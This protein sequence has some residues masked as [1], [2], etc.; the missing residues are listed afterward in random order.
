[1]W[2]TLSPAARHSTT[3][4]SPHAGLKSSKNSVNDAMKSVVPPVGRSY[5]PSQRSPL[6]RY[7]FAFDASGTIRSSHRAF[8]PSTLNSGAQAQR[9][10][11]TTGRMGSRR[12]GPGYMKIL[13]TKRSSTTTQNALNEE[14]PTAR[15]LTKGAVA[16]GNQLTSPRCTMKGSLM[17]RTGR[18]APSRACDESQLVDDLSSALDWLPSS[19]GA[20]DVHDHT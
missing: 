10:A 12:H 11:Q 20:D 9:S 16:S 8:C 6:W 15:A 1:M 14:M 18:F 17:H 19:R 7:P 4:E 13:S 2:S 5:M 3:S